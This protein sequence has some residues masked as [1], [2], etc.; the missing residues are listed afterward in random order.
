MVAMVLSL[1]FI[2][3]G[4]VVAFAN[5]APTSATT[6]SAQCVFESSVVTT[7]Q[8]SNPHIVL[9][10]HNFGDTSQCMFSLQVSWGDGTVQNFTIPGGPNG[11]EHLSDHVYSASSGTF[12]IQATGSVLSGPCTFSPGSY[13]FTLSPSSCPTGTTLS[14]VSWTKQFPG[15]K[16]LSDLQVPFRKSATQFV[17][18]L[19]NAHANI[20][21]TATFRPVQRAWLMHYSYDIVSL[22][23]NYHIDPRKVPS[24]AGIPI[25]WV[26]TKT[27]GTYDQKASVAAALAMVNAYGISPFSKKHPLLVPPS[28]TSNHTHGW[29]M[30]MSVSWSGTLT[31]SN[32]SGVLI[33]ITS[34][35]RTSMNMQL[36][37]VAASYGVYHY[38]TDQS[39]SPPSKDAL[40]WS[41]D[42][43]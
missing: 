13:Q 41:I 16:S 40:H 2:L 20:N 17:A 24:I 7:C 35:P 22:D 3:G 11:S 37:Q 12:H 25:C 38:G 32:A 21:I 14:D 23:P 33:K 27:D 18:A 4:S 6:G 8:S 1:S 9:N 36:W 15:S 34:T 19:S 5:P 10:F 39:T 26:H 30:D 42:G 28:L 43:K 31:I 29:A